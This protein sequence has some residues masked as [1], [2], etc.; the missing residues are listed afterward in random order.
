MRIY[1]LLFITSKKAPNSDL[2][3]NG[4]NYENT[5]NFIDAFK[6]RMQIFMIEKNAFIWETNILDALAHRK[7]MKTRKK[8]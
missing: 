8:L 1:I 2:K 6:G 7:P 3:L 4:L 5:K